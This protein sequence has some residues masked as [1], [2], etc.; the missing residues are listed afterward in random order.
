MREECSMATRQTR[1]ARPK[2]QDSKKYARED[3]AQLLAELRGSVQNR[4][5]NNVRLGSDFG[6]AERQG[7]EQQLIRQLEKYLGER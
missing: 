5:G 7:L 1:R 4:I 2:P 6:H 3:L